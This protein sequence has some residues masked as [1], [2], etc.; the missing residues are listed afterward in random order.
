MELGQGAG[1]RIPQGNQQLLVVDEVIVDH[2]GQDPLILAAESDA[3]VLAAAQDLVVLVVER[4][5]ATG[6]IVGRNAGVLRYL[7]SLQGGEGR[8][9]IRKAHEQVW[10]KVWRHLGDQARLIHQADGRQVPGAGI[11][12]GLLAARSVGTT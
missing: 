7:A 4:D 5:L 10:W 9:F 12:R 3:H 11:L 6:H 8:R 1:H 2:V